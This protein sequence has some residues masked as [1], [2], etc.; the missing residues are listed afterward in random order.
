MALWI[1]NLPTTIC[2]FFCVT[3][4]FVVSLRMYIMQDPSNS[5]WQVPGQKRLPQL[6]VGPEKVDQLRNYLRNLPPYQSS[7]QFSTG[8]SICGIPPLDQAQAPAESWSN[9]LHS[10]TSLTPT[11]GVPAG[12]AKF[13]YSRKQSHTL[14]G[15][16]YS[17]YN[18][19]A[20]PTSMSYP[21]SRLNQTHLV[22]PDLPSLS[23]MMRLRRDQNQYLQAPDVYQLNFKPNS[24]F[25]QLNPNQPYSSPTPGAQS[26][27]TEMQKV[28]HRFS[29]VQSKHEEEKK[30]QRDLLSGDLDP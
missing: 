14:P 9:N 6:T 29:M 3:I 7:A 12:P 16:Q 4:H 10:P 21:Q 26:S 11:L 30:A 25:A 28:R 19:P 8:S 2:L 22:H 23:F 20:Q 18:Y 15:N 27:L 17:F 13:E 1:S 24:R 5:S